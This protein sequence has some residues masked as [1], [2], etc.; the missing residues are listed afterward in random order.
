M[1]FTRFHDDPCRVAKQLQQSTDVGR[2]ILNVPGNGDKPAYMADPQVRIQTWGGNLMTN[3]IDLES[4]LRGVNRRANKDCLGKDEY[5]KYNV[6]TQAIQY[7]TNSALYTEESRTIMPAWTARDLEQ[8]NWYSLPLNPQENTC[9]P[10]QNNLSTRILE[11]DYFVA[12][13]PCSLPNVPG[14]LPV[15]QGKGS[16]SYPQGPQICTHENACEIVGKQ[17]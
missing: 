2:W 5:Q 8:V 7:P 13:I 9:M 4:E 14:S 10:F 16:L 3:C 11:K 17:K 12:Q 15:N 6:P 1:S